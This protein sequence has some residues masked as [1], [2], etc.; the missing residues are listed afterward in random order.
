[1][2]EDKYSKF[3]RAIFGVSQKA[4]ESNESYVARHEVLFEDLVA[5]GATLSDM[6]AY[7]LPRNST[8][9]SASKG[10]AVWPGSLP[11]RPLLKE[12]YPI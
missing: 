5:Q 9:T 1:M 7:L 10:G 12:S 2:L 4:D 6:R 3:E 11:L 8:L